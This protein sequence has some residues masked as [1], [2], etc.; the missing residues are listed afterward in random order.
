MNYIIDDK[1]GK[2]WIKNN[3]PEKSIIFYCKYINVQLAEAIIN[4]FKNIFKDES[5]KIQFVFENNIN[6]FLNGNSQFSAIELIDSFSNIHIKTKDNIETNVLILD[7]ERLINAFSY[8]TFK[9]LFIN[10][11]N[12]TCVNGYGIETSDRKLIEQFLSRYI[13]NDTNGL[14][15]K[16]LVDS[17]INKILE[18]D[19]SILEYNLY[20][21]VFNCPE[22]CT[23]SPNTIPQFSKFNKAVYDTPESLVSSNIIGITYN[24]LGQYL[25]E[26]GKTDFAYK[27]YGENHA[28]FAS[29]MD[30]AYIDCDRPRKIHITKLGNIFYN[31]QQEQ[32]HK[33]VLYQ[34]FKLDIIKV[35]VSKVL[36]DSSFDLS[37]YLKNYISSST[38]D[39]RRSNI[40]KIFQF[41]VDSD[42]DLARYILEKI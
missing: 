17:Y 4:T 11:N 33:L 16:Q 29:L 31:L 26:V 37:E 3:K 7:D 13:N 12:T 28:K 35:I 24:Q 30:F 22:N 6:N 20:S 14:N 18:L 2:E 38:V 8:E 25:E 41:I 9:N 10:C 34:V 42:I 36:N 32:Q 19:T 40:R 23:I 5:I 1:I 21:V 39:R 15:Y 27:K